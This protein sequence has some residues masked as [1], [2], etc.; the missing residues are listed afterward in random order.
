MTLAEKY[1]KWSY[2]S[3]PNHS[4]GMMKALVTLLPNTRRL[5]KSTMAS[6]HIT[7]LN[8]WEQ[9][10][11]IYF[12]SVGNSIYI[13]DI[14]QTLWTACCELT[15]DDTIAPNLSFTARPT[16]TE[17][18]NKLTRVKPGKDQCENCK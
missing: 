3:Y 17:C 6:E 4:L 7:V 1:Q 8:Y 10:G 12:N 2:P 9:Q 14:V 13:K 18:G 16:C 11:Y 15:W 5:D